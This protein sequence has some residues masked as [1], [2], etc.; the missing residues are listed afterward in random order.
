MAT[1]PI[2]YSELFENGI[3]KKV[4]DLAAAIKST[5]EALVKMLDDAKSRAGSLSQALSAANPG[6]PGGQQDILNLTK[7]IEQLIQRYDRLATAKSSL[8]N[9]DK[10]LAAATEEE[11]AA[12][13]MAKQAAREYNNEVKAAIAEM[14]LT[15]EQMKRLS[16]A[17]EL[18]KMSYNE[19]SAAYSQLVAAANAMHASNDQEVK[20]RQRL[21]QAAAMVREEQKRLK[22]A[23]GNYTL[24]VGNYEKAFNG[25][26]LAMQQIVRETPTITMGARMYFMAI[27]NN[28]PILTD[29]I[30]RIREEN[31]ARKM[32]IDTM[33]AE[34]AAMA[35]IEALQKQQISVGK[36]LLSSLFS[37]QTAMILGIT[38]LTMYGDKIIDWIADV[39]SAEG[40]TR[41]WKEAQEDLNRTFQEGDV[42]AAKAEA[43]A[44]VL[45]RIATDN[46]RATEDRIKAGE[47]LQKQY[48]G[49]FGDLSTEEI[50]LGKAT[51][52]HEALTKAL[53]NQAIARAYLDK[54]TELYGKRIDAE[55][56]AD[57]TRSDYI[58]YLIGYEKQYGANGNDVAIRNSSDANIYADYTR[59]LAARRNA[60]E[61]AQSALA[62]IDDEIQKLIDKIPVDGLMDMLINGGGRKGKGPKEVDAATAALDDLKYIRMAREAALNNIED[63]TERELA[64]TK[65]KYENELADLKA[66][67]EQQQVVMVSINVLEQQLA[68]ETTLEKR[69]LIQE[70]INDLKRQWD[71]TETG[72]QAVNDAIVEKEIDLNNKLAEIRQKRIDRLV[73]DQQ[74]ILKLQLDLANQRAENDLEG[75]ALDAQK[76]QNQIYYWTAMLASMEAFND[77]SK[78]AALRIEIVRETLR[79]LLQALN[80]KPEDG[81]WFDKLFGK[82]AKLVRGFLRDLERA[83]KETANNIKDIIGLYE[84]MAKA[85]VKAAQEQV[86]SSERVYEAEL[87]AYENGYANNVEFA[88]KELELRRNT[89]AEAEARERRYAEMKEKVDAAMNMASMIRTSYN[90]AESASNLMASE[91]KWGVIG[92]GI[93]AAAIA[94]MFATFAAAR[95]QARKLS[96]QQY[97]EGG[98]EYIDYGNSHASGHDV[99]FGTMPDGRPRRIERGE[100][101]AVINAKQTGR[102]GYSTVAGIINS[103][104]KGEFVEKYMTAFSGADGEFTMNVAGAF[105]SPYLSD[106]SR[107]LKAIRKGG[108][109]NETTLS[110]GTR[111]IR[112]KN[113]TRRIK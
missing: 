10:K 101:V 37:W 49:Y 76:I 89:L 30:K 5:D 71:I 2:K 109:Y 90:L 56:K 32:K 94:A 11:Y 15:E 108:E 103:I 8:A 95:I 27:S 24:S 41:A 18:Q 105:D 81:S 23:M 79:G 106:I 97:G 14:K 12:R 93:A 77:G 59:R 60:S 9:A 16:N 42:A 66:F 75:D 58:N 39:F 104:N 6:T 35:E 98:T 17:A 28:L 61:E 44:D 31:V 20:D 63:D 62:A 96:A 51:A 85:A 19:L 111:I 64:L 3:E 57:E 107:D 78:E 21:V 29:Q 7:Q 47:I 99:D 46:T 82:D 45:Y 36:Q 84:D 54:I 68:Q 48:E 50:M 72:V 43:Q 26:D 65:F 92:V 25:L 52:A 1:N 33:K 87:K 13:E 38:L 69:N 55:T 22:E 88:R 112:Y 4:S 91:S 83:L 86:K 80:E 34:G 70:Q 53:V 110:D 74:N 102:Y 67:A 113:Y 73:S 100:T 40:A